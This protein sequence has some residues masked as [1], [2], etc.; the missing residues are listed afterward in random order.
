MPQQ[1]KKQ[2]SQVGSE[3]A[4]LFVSNNDHVHMY[5]RALNLS[6]HLNVPPQHGEQALLWKLVTVVTAL[7]KRA[8]RWVIWWAGL[9]M[10]IT[11]N[12]PATC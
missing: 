10:Y 11:A 4:G 5:Y 7:H 8:T 6:L 3:Q 9:Q 1:C 12:P 2:G